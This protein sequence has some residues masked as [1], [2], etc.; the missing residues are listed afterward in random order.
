MEII[1]GF[2]FFGILAVLAIASFVV[3]IWALVDCLTNRGL[4]GTEKL[5]WVLVIIFLHFLGAILYLLLGRKETPSA[6]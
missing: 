3:W 4:D 6:Y 2:A 5:V 1:F